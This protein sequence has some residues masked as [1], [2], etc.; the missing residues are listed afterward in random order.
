[1]GAL[2]QYSKALEERTAALCAIS[3]S[4]SLMKQALGSEGIVDLDPMLDQRGR[5]IKRYEH[6]SAKI[7]DE[8]D[9][10]IDAAKRC[11]SDESDDMHRTTSS[12]IAMQV[13][14][15]SLAENVLTCQQECEI[16]LKT[17]LDVTAKAIHESRHRRKLDAAYGPAVS[18]RRQPVFLDKQR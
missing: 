13:E 5:E 7:G 12:L 6:V 8:L 10:L 3:H 14:H 17:R 9:R 18:H 11:A 1:M 2:R 15:Q 4:T 16:M